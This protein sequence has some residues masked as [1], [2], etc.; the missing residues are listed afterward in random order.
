MYVCSHIELSDREI[1]EN[2]DKTNIIAI[3]Y[4]E[5]PQGRIPFSLVSYPVEGK[6][7]ETRTL[8]TVM[9]FVAT[10]LS[11]LT[12]DTITLKN[13]ERRNIFR[14]LYEYKRVEQRASI[15]QWFMNVGNSVLLI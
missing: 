15:S 8:G 10:I 7:P 14:K 2:V 12:S 1:A 6:R 3:D 9:L 4:E 5:S 13:R 11:V